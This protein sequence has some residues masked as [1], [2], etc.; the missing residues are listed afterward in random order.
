MHASASTALV[1]SSPDDVS[2]RPPLRGLALVWI[3]YALLLA[4]ADSLLMPQGRP[5]LSFYLVHLAGASTLL[6][7]AGRP[8]RAALPASIGWIVA[9]TTLATLPRVA[10]PLLTSAE[11]LA[12][13]GLPV[14][15]LAL[16]LV[17]WRYS[18][19]SML[20]FSM[21]AAL[22][23]CVPLLL[24]SPL[25]DPPMGPAIV[26]VAIQTTSF[27]AVG[28]AT[29]LLMRQLRAQQRDLER[30]NLQLRRMAEL[31]EALAI[32]DE[33]S[34]IA[35]ELHDTLAHT[36]SGVS[37]QLEGVEACWERNPER[38]R[39]I[40]AQ[41]QQLVRGGL[42]ETR[43]ALR[44]LRAGPLE[45]HG[46]IDA[47]HSLAAHTATQASLALELQLP[48][49]PIALSPAAE[50]CLYRVAQEAL[51]N[52]ARH[53]S[54]SSLAVQLRRDGS[55]VELLVRDDG[56]GFDPAQLIGVGQYGLNGLRERALLLGGILTVESR[57]GQG[58]TV[59]LR[60][61]E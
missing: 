50:H 53:A 22:L 11:G 60:L 6:L 55:V 16:L 12:L 27:L 17:A 58:T 54:A 1:S 3:G 52:A 7:V 32:S 41:V 28:G 36:L 45:A 2:T 8:W 59:C 37:I 51:A 57:L 14:L 24:P 9:I 15:I 42:H 10:G 49:A 19:R 34:R 47:L 43:R 48:T 18:W 25:T 31:R 35:R 40:V 39:A 26:V 23:A 4:L 20:A 5:A 56:R 46:L 61:V 21:G 44:A 29:V 33:R 13:R 38:A 30:A